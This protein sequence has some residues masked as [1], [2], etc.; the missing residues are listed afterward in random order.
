MAVEDVDD[1]LCPSHDLFGIFHHQPV[2]GGEVWLSLSTVE[3][4]GVDGFPFGRLEL[5]V[6]GEGCPT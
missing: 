3:D 4:E 2:I 6:R 5:H 1:D